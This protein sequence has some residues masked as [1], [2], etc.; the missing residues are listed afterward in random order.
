MTH[1]LTK[2]QL[3]HILVLNSLNTAILTAIVCFKCSL[4]ICNCSHLTDV[5]VIVVTN[6]ILH[7]NPYD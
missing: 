3:H 2:R 4:F 5:N 7:N 1:Y 6:R